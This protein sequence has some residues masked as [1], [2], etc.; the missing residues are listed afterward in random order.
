MEMSGI[1]MNIFAPHSVRSSTMSRAN[2]RLPLATILH[3]GGW[4]AATSFTRHY[5]MPIATVCDVQTTILRSHTHAKKTKK[6]K[7]HKK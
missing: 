6:H 7:K 3:T 2:T 4:F 5:D 1:D